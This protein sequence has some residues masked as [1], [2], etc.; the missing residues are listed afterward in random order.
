MQETVQ[1][2]RGSIVD[3]LI[4]PGQALS[5]RILMMIFLLMDLKKNLIDEI[6]LLVFTSRNFHSS[7][8]V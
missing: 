1:F 8:H 2:H 5:T 3:C 4:H 6:Q 7:S